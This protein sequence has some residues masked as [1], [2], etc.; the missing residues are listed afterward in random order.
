MLIALFIVLGY[1]AMIA[2]MYLWEAFIGLGIE[3][4]RDDETP[5]LNCA[6]IFWPVSLPIILVYNFLKYVEHTTEKRVE[7]SR[8]EERIQKKREE[9][10]ER[11][12]IVAQ[13]EEE[14]I[15]EQVEKELKGIS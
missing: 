4:S 15:V 9:Q 7:R 1:L 11:L 14:A 13:K 10:Q 8:Q 6:A 3:W 5:G 2:G 12:R